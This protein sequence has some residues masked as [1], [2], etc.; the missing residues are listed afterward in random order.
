MLPLLPP[1][2]FASRVQLT[3]AGL[4]RLLRLSALWP[5]PHHDPVGDWVLFICDPVPLPSRSVCLSQLTLSIKLS[6]AYQLCNSFQCIIQGIWG[7]VMNSDTQVRKECSA[8]DSKLIYIITRLWAKLFNVM[9]WNLGWN[10]NTNVGLEWINYNNSKR[11][12]NLRR[13]DD[14]MTR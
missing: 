8:F 7:T 5:G 11:T 9:R 6:G 3:L 10:N 13:Y 4:C 2:L 14:K 1:V 12:N